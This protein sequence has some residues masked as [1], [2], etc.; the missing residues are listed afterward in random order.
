MVEKLKIYRSKYRFLL[1]ALFLLISNLP[2]QN[3]QQVEILN[4]DYMEFDRS[5]GTGVV[6]YVGDVAFRQDDMLLYCDSAWLFSEE[7]VVHAYDSVHIIQ[8]DTL[9][10]YGDILK[11]YGNEKIAEVWRNVKLVDKETTLLT[12]SLEFDLN[13][14]TGYYE[15]HGRL[16]NGDNT[17]DS[18]RGYYY[19]NTNT[20]HFMDSVVIV[21]PDYDIFADTLKYHTE[22]EIAYFLG[23]THIVS[24]DNYIYC[25]NGWYD[26]Q[27]DISQFNENAYLESGGQFLR[28]DSLYYERDL[29]MG[30]A[31][32]HVELY[33]SANEVILLGKYALYFE[34]PEFA[35]LT[36]SAL[37][38]QIS[39][40]DSLFVHADTLTSEAFVDTTGEY[41]ILR[42]YYRVKIFSEDM[43]GKCDSLSYLEK[44][45]VFQLTGEPVIWS[46]SYQLTATEIDLHMANDEPD[47]IDL[48]SSSFIVAKDDSTRY[49]QIKGRN[50]KGYF[51][52][53]SLSNLDVNGNGQTIYFARDEEQLIGVNKAESSNIKIFFEEG[54][55]DRI[56]MLTQPAAVLYPP[57]HLP[58]EEMYLSGFVWLI[59]HR[60][61]R[62]EDVYKWIE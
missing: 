45:S 58:K 37:L 33:D 38:I 9:H 21:N 31:F 34:E 20:V 44:D 40:G 4:S 10:L 23:P 41:K 55:L 30:K 42:A 14:N 24:P 15:R 57:E 51:L 11:Y 1:P 61:M 46:E 47:Y 35:M 50:M 43:Q 56:N 62:R 18:E 17:L 5:I 19:T 26:T 27:N 52:E 12:E 32:D 16:I 39:E 6:K 49:T 36:D 28:G 8:A 59:K 29:G 3:E 25:E 13:N 2:A 54:E 60:P 53:G 7:N 48:T 22:T